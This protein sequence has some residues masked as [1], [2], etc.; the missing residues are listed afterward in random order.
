VAGDPAAGA[1]AFG[2]VNS[3][4]E[5]SVEDIHAFV[6]GCLAAE[7]RAAVA[8][9]IASDPALRESTDHW[10]QQNE[11]I[12][13]AY[14]ESYES[15]PTAMA[16]A[17][18]APT[19]F[20]P[21]PTVSAP[22]EKPVA[23]SPL[24]MILMAFACGAIATAACFL[25]FGGGERAVGL[26]SDEFTAAALSGYHGV[27]HSGVGPFDARSQDPQAMREAFSAL[28]GDATPVPDLSSEGLTAKAVRSSAGA[29]SAAA[30]VVYEDALGQAFALFIEP[31][32][33]SRIS[34]GIREGDG[35]LAAEW[36]DSSF[37]YAVLGLFDRNRIKRLARQIRDHGAA[38]N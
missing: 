24:W 38:P 30:I 15:R 6:D 35:V 37:A 32:N 36:A 25:A 22:S 31:S 26:S 3:R 8:Q 27:S 12:C 10:V 11:A 7:R 9:R 28:I 20:A 13:L 18:R 33:A 29:R 17:P 1:F 19:P 16:R 21:R 4:V 2:E 5:L 14:A 34:E 23:R